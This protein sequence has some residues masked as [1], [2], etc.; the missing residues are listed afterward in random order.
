MRIND[1]TF[2][3]FA[4]DDAMSPT[5][6][7]CPR[8]R[9]VKG[10]SEFRVRG[11][12]NRRESYCKLCQR[13]YSKSHYRANSVTYIQRARSNFDQYVS[14]NRH[15]IKALLRL[16]PCIDCGESDPVVLEFDHVTDN[17]SADVSY[18]V[19]QGMRWERI[20]LEI[21]KCQVRCANCHRRKTDKLWA[22]SRRRTCNNDPG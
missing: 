4:W 12:R 18:M 13:E 19:G 2:G 11:P 20:E 15:R 21:A 22:H 10:V 17:K 7:R 6:K 3:G 9:E 1:P 16:H 14:R 8:C 5:T